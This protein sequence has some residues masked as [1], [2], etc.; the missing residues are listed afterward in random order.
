MKNKYAALL[1]QLRL[2]EE[3]EPTSRD[4]RVL[5]IDG[6]NTFIRSYSATPTL[7]ANGEHVGGIS[8]F[9][10]S[11]GSAIKTIN[12][13]RVVVVFDGKDSSSKRRKLFPNY[14]A[15]RKIKIRLNRA[16][17][18]DKEDNQL[19]QLVRLIDYLETLP[20]TVITLDGCEA[21]DVMAYI[22]NR[23]VVP[24]D[25][26]AFIMSSDKDFL[27]LASNNIHVWSP[28]KKKLYYE[29]DVYAEYGVYPKN[30][31]IFRA[32]V[33]DSSDNIPGAPGLAAK[34]II[35]RFPKLAEADFVSLDDFFEYA[36]GLAVQSKIKVFHSVV[37][38]E[39]DIRLYYKIMQL[40][41]TLINAS[42][43]SNILNL[44]RMEGRGLSKMDFHRLLVEDGMT[45]AIRNPEAWLRE[46]GTKLNQFTNKL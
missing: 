33:G 41:E 23:I 16:Q 31:S 17:S 26:H 13:T 4:D 21:D 45:N 10:A 30:F 20:I 11:M 27:Q 18:V 15:N 46:V 7:N 25:A 35:K 14:K 36:K 1:N 2:R 8:G 44:M 5:L 6:L 42:T 34:T 38:N 43:Q 22:A 19:Q 24:K 37:D 39:D 29:D 9:L 32:L 28:T 40:H 12:P 3:E